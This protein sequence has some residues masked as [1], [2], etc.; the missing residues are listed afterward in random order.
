MCNLLNGERKIVCW[1]HLCLKSINNS[2][3]QY[4]KKKFPLYNKIQGCLRQNCCKN[5]W[6]IVKCMRQK[7]A[8]KSKLPC[9]KVSKSLTH[10]F[11]FEKKYAKVETETKVT[12]LW[13]LINTWCNVHV[14]VS[15]TLHLIIYIC[16]KITRSLSFVFHFTFSYFNFTVSK[17]ISVGTWA[18]PIL[19]FLETYDEHICI[20]FY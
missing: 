7:L 16:S 13:N 19:I 1:M 2:G 6:E 5:V 12:M 20:L 18:P 8:K 14:S 11:L 15:L 17:I 3:C 4:H 10:M 9:S